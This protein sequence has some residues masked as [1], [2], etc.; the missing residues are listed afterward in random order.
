MAAADSGRKRTGDGGASRASKRK[1]FANTVRGQPD[2][3][4]KIHHDR[5]IHSV[6]SKSERRAHS[7]TLPPQSSRKDGIPLGSRGILISCAG[8][9]ENIAAREAID[10]FTQVGW[11]AG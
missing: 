2:M 8:G 4:Y 7:T 3:A 5:P 9:K 6:E 11:V 10:V 1:Y